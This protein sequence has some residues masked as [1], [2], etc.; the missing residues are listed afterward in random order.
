MHSESVFASTGAANRHRGCPWVVLA[1]LSV[2]LAGCGRQAPG[3]GAAAQTGQAG[4]GRAGGPAAVDVVLASEGTLRP[5]REYTGTTRPTREV[6][7]RARTEGRLLT[8]AADVGDRVARGQVLARLD[9][10]LL[11]AAVSQAEAELA[12]RQSELTSAQTQVGAART[13]VEQ[14]RL[15]LTQQRADAD[16]YAFLAREGAGPRQTAEQARTAALT[17]AQVLRSE[18]Q[19]V[20]N[21]QAA[22]QAAQARVRAQRAAVAQQ[23]ERLSYAVLRSPVTGY[24]TQKLSDVGNLVQPG[25]E[26]LRLGD[27]RLA[28]VDVQVS[29]LELPGIRLGQTVRV[30]LDA[31]GDR[32]FLGRVDRISPQ[33]DPVTRLVPVTI[34]L[35][36]PDSRIG[37][38]L[39]ARARF[40]QTA[41]RKIVIPETALQT[42]G[43]GPG[44]GGPAPGGPP[45]GAAGAPQAGGADAVRARTASA[46]DQENVETVFVIAGEGGTAASAGAANGREGGQAPRASARTYTVAARRVR[47]GARADGQAE[48]L[49]GLRAGDRV[50][51][52]SAGPLTD[53]APVRPSILS[54]EALAARPGRQQGQ[55]RQG[56]EQGRVPPGLPRGRGPVGQGDPG[57]AG[58]RQARPA[59]QGGPAT[60]ASGSRGRGERQGAPRRGAAAAP[61]SPGASSSGSSSGVSPGISPGTSSGTQSSGSGNQ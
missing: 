16:R 45:A 32:Q 47:V 50:V 3:G 36:N 44:A 28:Q 29:E 40:G 56:Q 59:A 18:E 41:E 15:N 2:A 7:L 37:G 9:D 6:T 31:Y 25:G 24:V 8:L 14:A 27:F 55:P 53:G 43:R 33:A 52:R 35:P 23:R 42:A 10:D 30:L 20:R 17:G 12:S 38:G 26:I 61:A 5:E 58:G 39:L 54:E 34:T 57:Q 11:R 46:G 48:I 51:S 21:L 13:R 22:V 4:A 49:S 1:A 60:R 19:Q